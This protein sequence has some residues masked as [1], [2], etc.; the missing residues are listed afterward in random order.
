LALCDAIGDRTREARIR[1]SLARPTARA[2]SPT[3]HRPSTAPY[4]P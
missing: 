3:R 4:S 2:D 1:D